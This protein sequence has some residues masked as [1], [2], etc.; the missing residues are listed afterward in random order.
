MVLLSGFGCT[1]VQ[2]VDN[3]FDCGAICDR[4]KS[5]FDKDY[6]A[7]ACASRCRAKGDDAAARRTADVCSACITDRSC[8]AATF[9][10]ATECVSIVP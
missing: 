8:A 3:V 4:Y 9:S 10:C 5:C 7:A 2:K 1:V 6:D